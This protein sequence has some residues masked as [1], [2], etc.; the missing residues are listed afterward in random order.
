MPHS[1]NGCRTTE[2]FCTRDSSSSQH[3]MC[4]CGVKRKKGSTS[5]ENLLLHVQTALLN[6]EDILSEDK[7]VTQA[8]IVRF[9]ASQKSKGYYGWFNFITNGLL[10]FSFVENS[11][12]CQF[13]NFEPISLSTLIR[14]LPKLT[15]YA[16]EKIF[17]KLPQKIVLVFDGWSTGSTHILAIY[18]SFPSDDPAGCALQLL[19]F[20]PMGHESSLNADEHI[21]FISTNRSIADKASVPLIGCASHR[22]NLAVQAILTEEE[23]IL[24]KISAMMSK[25]KNLTLA[26]ELFPLCSLRAKTRK[27]T[28]WIS[29]SEMCL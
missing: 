26:A 18:A 21:E 10:P 16:E 23:D 12:V 13:S 5:Y 3:W 14:Y 8:Q 7:C 9:F 24:A 4:R 11:V 17:V 22:F 2:L 19:A 20:S 25:L 6:F 29:D 28:R 15:A 1:A 27:V